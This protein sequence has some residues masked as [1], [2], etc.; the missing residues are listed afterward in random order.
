M[1]S[2]SALELLGQV[3]LRQGRLAEAVDI[4]ASMLERN[5][6][7]QHAI[8]MDL[9]HRPLLLAEALAAAGRCD[10]AVAALDRADA[11]LRARVAAQHP[12]HRRL[13]K[14]R[15]RCTAVR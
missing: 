5:R 2:V 10:E 8:R 6:D 4:F 9:G 14:V 7:N 12:L 11:L 3:R 15:D 13:S 1:N